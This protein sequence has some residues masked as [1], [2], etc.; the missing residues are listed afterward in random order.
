[1]SNYTKEN[2]V[3]IPIDNV[4]AGTLVLKVGDTVL[5]TGGTQFTSENSAVYYKC[6]SVDKENKTWTGYKAVL[7]GGVYSFETTP[8]V[9]LT[10][11]KGYTPIVN[12][13]YNAEASVCIKGV[14]NGNTCLD[15]LTIAASLRSPT[16]E[17]GNYPIEIYSGVVEFNTTDEG[18]NF[19]FI[20]PHDDMRGAWLK[21]D[22]PACR[23]PIGS[24]PDNFTM[25][26]RC[27][28]DGDGV[29]LGVGQD[30]Y[31]SH[32][33]I[34]FGVLSGRYQIYIHSSSITNYFDLPFYD[35]YRRRHYVL[36]R[37][38]NVW[39]IYYDG[40]LFDTQTTNSNFSIA[41][42]NQYIYIGGLMKG[43][44]S[45]FWASC[46]GHYA[47]FQF[48]NRTLSDEEVSLLATMR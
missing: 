31:G 9:N 24:I 21:E 22:Y 16:P 43:G 14:W 12:E 10:Y 33:G 27:R 32:S 26:A 45:T 29:V 13:I 36:S 11:G 17:I 7:T 46:R 30:V 4:P 6:A 39:K 42:D 3:P 23:I 19:P 1:M 44:T 47:D 41:E 35:T 2:L 40:V 48:Y 8:T 5:T 34:G 28:I 15:G 20:E 18:M 25:A 37:N 38:K